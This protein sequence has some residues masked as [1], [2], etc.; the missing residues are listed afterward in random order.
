L[1]EEYFLGCDST[2]WFKFT[3][4]LEECAP[5]NLRTKEHCLIDFLFDLEGY[6]ILSSLTSVT[7]ITLH[8]FTFQ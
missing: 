7:S 4:G 5:S 1:F 6:T 2:G 3:D 8:G